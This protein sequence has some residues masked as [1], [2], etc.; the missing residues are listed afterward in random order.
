MEITSLTKLDQAYFIGEVR[1]SLIG[2][3]DYCI[4]SAG[5]W[6]INNY[7]FASS[8]DLDLISLPEMKLV[9]AKTNNVCLHLQR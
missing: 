2:K 9:L 5:F 7:N 4:R 3:D 6:F 1:P 8:A